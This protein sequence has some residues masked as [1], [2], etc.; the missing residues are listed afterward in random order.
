MTADEK[1]REMADSLPQTAGSNADSRKLKSQ[2]AGDRKVLLCTEHLVKEFPIGGTKKNPLVVHAVSD[3]NLEIYEGETLALVGESGCGK[4]T[5]GRVLIRL[6]DATSGKVEFEGQDIT[7]M[8]ES[9]FAKIRRQLQ[10]IFQDPYASLNPRMSVAKIIAEP[11]TTY[12]MKDKKELEARVKELMK[13]V[14]IPEEFYNRYPHQFSGG[15]RQRISIARAIAIHP[16]FLVCDE[17]TSA[18]DVSVQAQVLNLMQ[19]LQREVGLTYLFISHNLLVVHH[20]SD[21]VGVMYLGRLVELADKRTLFN[22]PRHPYTRML[23]DAIP[24]LSQTHRRR[25]PISGEVPNPLSPPTGCPFHPRCPLA[26]ERC[27]KEM[28]LRQMIDSHGSFSEVAC[29]AAEEGRL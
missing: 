6:L 8:K 7:A 24:D 27:R 17:P 29:H 1:N 22:E 10:I 26:N 5:L 23:L 20:I 18:L 3:V 28:P 12:G 21:R 14:G 25:T 2:T 16:E 9:E 11:L 4:S 15:Q 19:N 13:E